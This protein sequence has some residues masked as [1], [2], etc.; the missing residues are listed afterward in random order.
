MHFCTHVANLC[1]CICTYVGN[2]RGL[3]NSRNSSQEFD[4]TKPGKWFSNAN[5]CG[6]DSIWTEYAEFHKSVLSGKEKQRYL[7]YVCKDKKCGGYGNR[8]CG[9]TVLLLYAMLTKRALLLDVTNPVHIDSYLLP[10]GIEWNHHAAKGLT[11]RNLNIMTFANFNEVYK[12]FEDTLLGDQYG[13]VSVRINFGLFYVLE[14]MNDSLLHNMISMLHLRT[15]Y[16]LVMLYGC[17]YNYLFKYQPKTFDAIDTL[18][19]ELGLETG[20]YV[21]MHVRSHIGDKM[22]SLRVN[23]QPMFKCAIE[24]AKTMSRQLGISKVPIFLAA[25]H[26]LVTEYAMQYYNDSIVLSKAPS[27][28]SDLTRYTGDNATS[29][30][31]EGMIGLFSDMELCSR[32]G[33]LVRSASSTL[34]EVIGAIH[35]PSPKRHYHPFYFYTNISVCQQYY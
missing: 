30:Y 8:I 24:A 34:S 1:T 22:H 29:Q 13:I 27:F 33:V 4:N 5:M 26:P 21:A 11:T 7:K 18:Q 14:K 3:I 9:I 31:Y 2:Y 10:H 23:F 19:H 6:G 35:F 15:H 32:A 16:D 17:A 28:H 25:D 12:N 20:K